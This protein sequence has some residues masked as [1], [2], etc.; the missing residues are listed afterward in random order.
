MIVKKKKGYKLQ[1]IIEKRPVLCITVKKR[2][3][4]KHLAV[5]VTLQ[6]NNKR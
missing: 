1:I 5:T 3:R 6:A 2:S 4:R